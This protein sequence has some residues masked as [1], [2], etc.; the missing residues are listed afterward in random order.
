MVDFRAII[1][2]PIFLAIAGILFGTVFLTGIG[3]LANGTAGTA[4]A[5]C[6]Q[7]TVTL[8]NNLELFLVIAGVLAVIGVALSVFVHSKKN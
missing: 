3:S 8:L 6:Q 7:T 1:I 4:C 2:L 5:N